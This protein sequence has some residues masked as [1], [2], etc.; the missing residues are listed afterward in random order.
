VK[1]DHDHAEARA[2]EGLRVPAP[3]PGIR[4]TALRA[5]VH[6]KGQRIFLIALEIRRLD[7]VAEHVLA[8]RAV[9]VELLEVAEFALREHGL[10][11]MAELRRGAAAESHG[12]QVGGTSQ[13]AEGVEHFARADTEALDFTGSG[14][15]GGPAGGRIDGPQRP[16]AQMVG[17][18]QTG[19]CR[20]ATSQSLRSSGPNSA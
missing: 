4:E 16:L 2:G 8:V 14:D 12:V 3:V 6:Q 11:H 9:E 20:R 5:A 10:V 13:I 19:S 1:I 18:S 7:D 17:P 15:R